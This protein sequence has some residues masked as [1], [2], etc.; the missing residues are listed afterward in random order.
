MENSTTTLIPEQRPNLGDVFPRQQV[1]FQPHRAQESYFQ[2]ASGKATKTDDI[3]VEVFKFLAMEPNS[4]LQWLLDLCN[5]CWRATVVPDEWS[6]ASVAM[7]FKKGTQPIRTITDQFVYRVLRTSCLPPSSNNGFL[8]QGYRT[9]SG[10]HN[11][12]LETV[13][14]L[15]MPFSLLFEK[16]NKPVPSEVVRSACWPS[17][18]RK[19]FDSINLDKPS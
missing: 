15:K 3:P 12:D 18:G 4:S 19:P 10:N 16:S 17:I 6:T 13:I 8:M 5:H 11:S 2:M 9:D 1:G 14:V 7:L